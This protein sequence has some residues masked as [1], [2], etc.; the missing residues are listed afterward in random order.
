MI[1]RRF[2]K[3]VEDTAL[4]RLIRLQIARVIP[5]GQLILALLAH[6]ML[7]YVFHATDGN[8]FY[9]ATL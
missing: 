4:L 5:L 8:I 7:P 6:N 1:T 9:E 2:H 3:L